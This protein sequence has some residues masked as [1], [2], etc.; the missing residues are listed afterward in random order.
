MQ[1]RSFASVHDI[2]SVVY[3]VLLS[4]T[5]YQH[6]VSLPCPTSIIN[7]R[8]SSPPTPTKGL[9]ARLATS[10]ARDPSCEDDEEIPSKSAPSRPHAR[11]TRTNGE[12]P[13]TQRSSTTTPIALPR[14]STEQ[15]PQP[16]Q[17]TNSPNQQG[18][19]AAADRITE[20]PEHPT[21]HPAKRSFAYDHDQ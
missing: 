7:N 20:K 21:L 4:S 14:K 8:K 19:V 12:H 3:L 15:P 5:I 10:S 18:A 11:S 17:R 6:T 1:H 16:D 2:R 9:C 13:P